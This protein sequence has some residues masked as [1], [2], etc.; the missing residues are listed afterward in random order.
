[1]GIDE[2]GMELVPAEKAEVT[3]EALSDV[4]PVRVAAKTLSGMSRKSGRGGNNT[5]TGRI[6]RPRPCRQQ[7]LQLVRIH[8]T[9]A[10]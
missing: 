1:M 2:L 5:L 4:G 10:H 7:L 9:M 6:H 3:S 8:Q